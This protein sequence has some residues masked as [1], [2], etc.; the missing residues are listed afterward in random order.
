MGDLFTVPYNPKFYLPAS[1]QMY[2]DLKLLRTKQIPVQNDATTKHIQVQQK[3]SHKHR[4]D[5]REDE[6]NEGGTER[7]QRI[8]G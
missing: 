5:L 4:T 1:L 8:V 7:I 2:V 6:C 3:T